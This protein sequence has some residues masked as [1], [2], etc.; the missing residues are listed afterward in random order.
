M[1]ISFYHLTSSPL[2][3]ALPALMEKLVQ[4]GKRAVLMADNEELL[5][6]ID[7]FLWTFS[8][9]RFVPHGM[10]EDGYEEKQPIYLTSEEEN[11]N[12]AEI[13]VTVGDVEPDFRESFSRWLVVFDGANDVELNAMRQ[14]WKTLNAQ[15]SHTLAYWKQGDDGKWQQAA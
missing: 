1:D 3:K 11:P 15:E 5:K 8:T 10:K 12:K 4:S 14:K 7:Q 2:E 6:R 9:N 13:L